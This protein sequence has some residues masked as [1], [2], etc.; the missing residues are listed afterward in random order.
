MDV[1]AIFPLWGKLTKN[2]LMGFI[3]EG[4]KTLLVAIN[5]QKLDHS[6]LGRT[7]TKGFYEDIVK[8]DGI[9]PCAENGEYH[10][11]IYDGPLFKSAVKFGKGSKS[12]CGNHSYVA[13]LD[14]VISV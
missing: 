2:L 14:T 12:I 8:L 9:D 11:F 7:I 13:L 5:N 4:F 1:E 10:T 3:E 6:W